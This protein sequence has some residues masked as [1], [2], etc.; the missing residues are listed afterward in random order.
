MRI[1]L[2]SD[3]H[4][5]LYA[6]ISVLE[7]IENKKANKIY[8]LGDIVGYHSFPNEVVELI[9]DR[10][11]ISIKGNHD[12]DITEQKFDKSKESDFI[13]DWTYENLKKEN[14]EF[15][16][17]LPESL[18]AE[19][20]DKKIKLVH[21][22]TTSIEE[23]LH[24]NSEASKKTIE[25][26]NGDI[27][28]CAHTHF[29]YIKYYDNKM[30]INTG[31]IGKPKIGRPNSTYILLD[32]EDKNIAVEI[33]EVAYNF[34]LAAEDMRIKNLPKKFIDALISGKA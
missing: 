3:I 9:R 20:E 24:E 11:I 21:G 25:E 16:L 18:E 7:D 31:R 15:L 29:P 8:C 33:V 10:K 28:V 2:I 23:Y 27:L 6:L 4:S 1:A 13:K 14:R 30:L 19:Y 26:F 17:S 34:Q 5:N 32:I 22:S 12:K